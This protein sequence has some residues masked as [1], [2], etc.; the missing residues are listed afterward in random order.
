MKKLFIAITALFFGLTGQAQ[1]VDEVV[2]AHVEAIGGK[3]KLAAL[4]SMYMESIS[5]MQNGNEVTSKIWK[6]QDKL[7]RRE[8]AFGMGQMTSIV[9]DK[10]GWNSNPRNGGTFEAVPADRLA[11]MKTEM[12]IAGPLVDYAAKGH[13]A[14][15]AGRED[16]NG[17]SCHVV[18]LT[19]FAG[20]EITYLIDPK[21]YYIVRTKTKGGGFMRGGGGGGGGARNPEAEMV[22]DYSDHRKTPE[23]YVF[24]YTIT[25]QGMGASQNVE[26]LEVN[27]EVDAKL[28]KPGN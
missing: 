11:G 22:T 24:P 14:E 18:K 25:I 3:D 19:M 8:I 15:L 12:D 2:S 13:K 6:V 16:V 17:T 5:V 28:Y 20:R 4:K 10:E 27:K 23:G 21:T 1:T 9:T 26:K 7:M